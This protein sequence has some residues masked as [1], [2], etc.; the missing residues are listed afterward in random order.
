VTSASKPSQLQDQR[1]PAGIAVSS[2]RLAQKLKAA[3]ADKRVLE[4]NRC[5]GATPRLRS[6]VANRGQP[7]RMAVGRPRQVRSV[8]ESNAGG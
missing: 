6:S 5:L 2:E 4:Q 1:L 3:G 8:A 7:K